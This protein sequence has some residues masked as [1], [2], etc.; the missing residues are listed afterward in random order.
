MHISGQ[1][2]LLSSK[3]PY[4]DI[5]LCHLNITVSYNACLFELGPLVLLLNSTVAV[6][7]LDSC[8]CRTLSL[9][10]PTEKSNPYKA[11]LEAETKV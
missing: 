6:T 3:P 5:A 4:G 2:S 1:G 7:R 11:L 10:K 8:S 9:I